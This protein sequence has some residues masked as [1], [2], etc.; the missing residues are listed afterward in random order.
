MDFLPWKQHFS[1]AMSKSAFFFPQGGL[2]YWIKTC[3]QL[4]RRANVSFIR[5]GLLWE[6]EPDTGKLK[7]VLS[8]PTETVRERS[9][10]QILAEASPS[11]MF[12]LFCTTDTLWRSNSEML[13]KLD[14]CV[15]TERRGSTAGQS[16]EPK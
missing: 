15:Q 11:L 16:Q 6:Q 2:K 5:R 9:L 7:V 8:T 10:T 4:A 14:S 1:C 13:F 3:R 12:I